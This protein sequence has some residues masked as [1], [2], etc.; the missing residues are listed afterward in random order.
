MLELDEIDTDNKAPVSTKA[1]DRFGLLCSYCKQGALR[2][3]PQ[4][5]DCSSED[6]DGTK[7]KAK[8]ETNSLI[9]YNAPKPQTNIDQK[10][11]VKEIAFDKLQIGQSDPKEKPVEVTDSLIP[12]PLTEM[13][14]DTAGKNDSDKLSE[15][16]RKLQQEEENYE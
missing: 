15:A 3:S 12:P 2:P 13:L 4:E 16:K 11:N 6:C 8:E 9:N 10:T 14:E 5:S 1:C 7:A